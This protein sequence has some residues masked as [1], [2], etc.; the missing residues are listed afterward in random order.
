[1]NYQ[2]QTGFLPTPNE[3]YASPPAECRPSPVIEQQMQLLNDRLEVLVAQV[4][5]TEARLAGVL[6]QGDK[7]PTRDGRLAG[8][9]GVPLG[10]ML[11]GLVARAQEA[12]DRLNGIQERI[13][14]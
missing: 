7:Q 14:L 5:H 9:T 4:N 12:I 11:A 6:R 10:D 3:K 1:M 13:E 2:N 8:G